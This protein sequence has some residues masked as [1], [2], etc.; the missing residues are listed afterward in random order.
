MGGGKIPVSH[1]FC[2]NGICTQS[3]IK[4]IV[5]RITTKLYNHKV[6]F[7][8]MP[9]LRKILVITIDTTNKPLAKLIYTYMLIRK[10]FKDTRIFIV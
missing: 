8:N 4:N 3:I 7:C 5:N 2:I 9:L 1:C 10:N 6:P